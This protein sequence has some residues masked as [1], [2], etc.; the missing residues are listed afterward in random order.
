MQLS[1]IGKMNASQPGADA[2][3]PAAP[4]QPTRIESTSAVWVWDGSWWPATVTRALVHRGERVLIVR[5]EHG[6]T[7]PARPDSLQPR[8][9]HLS[10]TD[11]PRQ[12]ARVCDFPKTPE[13]GTDRC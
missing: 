13:L 1:S 12:S 2:V 8:D 5:F 7:A 11:K 9:P 4:Q 3:P 6:L 10:G